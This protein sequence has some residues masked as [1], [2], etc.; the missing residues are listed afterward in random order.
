MSAHSRVDNLKKKDSGMSTHSRVDSKKKKKKKKKKKST[1]PSSL[2]LCFCCL[3]LFCFV[4]YFDLVTTLICQNSVK[5][6]SA[7]KWLLLLK[8]QNY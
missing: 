5:Y 7:L 8:F 6:S 2:L 3:F 1:A 4:C